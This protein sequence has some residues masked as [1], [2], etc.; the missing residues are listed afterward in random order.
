M[1]GEIFHEWNVIS[2]A[3]ARRM[4]LG[5]QH[6]DKT[7]YIDNRSTKRKK[8]IEK[9]I[10]LFENFSNRMNIDLKKVDQDIVTYERIIKC[11]ND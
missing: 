10:E 7:D 4:Y 2:F 9:T 1:A 3:R 5:K 8:N 6:M 11:L